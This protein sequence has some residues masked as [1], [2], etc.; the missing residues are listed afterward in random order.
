[1]GGNLLRLLKHHSKVFLE[2]P[3]PD[4]PI[5]VA[6]RKVMTLKSPTLDEFDNTFTCIGGG[7]PPHFPFPNAK[8]YY[9]WGSS[10]K[11]ISQITVPFLALNADDDP[12]VQFVPM[13]GC[14]NGQVA[15]GLTKGGGHLGWFQAGAGFV[16][17]WTTKPILEWLKVMGKD[18]VHDENSFKRPETFVDEN[19]FL[20]ERGREHLGC[21]VIDEG[22]LVDE[23]SGYSDVLQGL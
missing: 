19:G 16:D 4:H 8:L 5:C 18:V 21:K 14:D 17:R 2:H 15:I 12:I 13:D 7:P 3:D 9:K 20:R 11:I 22:E 6:A 1:M 10:H 23:T